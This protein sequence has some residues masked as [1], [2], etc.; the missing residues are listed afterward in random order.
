[1]FDIFLTLA[2]IAML[3]FG[4]EILIRGAMS[5]A[6]RFHVS[7]L[8]IGLVIVGFGTS[9]PE[10]VVSVD[11]ALNQQPDVAIGN[12]VGSNIGNI[13]LILAACAVITPLTVRPLA[14]RRDAITLVA[15]SVLLLLL[16]MNDHVLSL[17]DAII[18][19]IVF[20]AYLSWTYISERKHSIPSATMHEAEADVM[21]NLPMRSAW[22]V[23]SI[24]LGL[25]FLITG[26]KV[27]LTGAIG[28]SRS[29]GISEAAIGLTIVAVGTS[30]PE[31]TISLIAAIRKQAD[32]AIGNVLGS[33]IFNVLGILG[34]AGLMQPLQVHERILQFDQW[35]MLATSLLL[36]LFLY[37]G[38]RLSRLEGAILLSGYGLYLWLSFTLFGG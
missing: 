4:G 16:F 29:M 2:G 20:S 8:L 30:F 15:S 21:S 36:L 23:A 27:L 37:T 7:P 6:R 10:L 3:A 9:A 38:K 34:V 33:N 26:S 28:L 1:M 12:V 14:L 11:A 22:I 17:L 5:A 31:L 18:L 32:V 13:L 35:V 24:L 19:L 25:I